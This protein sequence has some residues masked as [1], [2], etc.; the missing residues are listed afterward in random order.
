MKKMSIVLCAVAL[1]LSIN[2]HSSGVITPDRAQ[3]KSAWQER[4][5]QE[6]INQLVARTKQ[7]LSKGIEASINARTN[8]GVKTEKEAK[9]VFWKKITQRKK[10]NTPSVKE[11]FLDAY[12]RIAINLPNIKA[13]ALTVA[14]KNQ[15]QLDNSIANIAYAEAVNAWDAIINQIDPPASSCVIL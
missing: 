5:Y 14:P 15:E 6:E 11:K 4:N 8:Q 1:I 7:D 2:S 12:A 10:E 13:E 9:T 3:V